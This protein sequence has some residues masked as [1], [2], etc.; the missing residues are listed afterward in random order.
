MSRLVVFKDDCVLKNIELGLHDIVIGRGRESDV[1][2]DDL[3]R[4]VSRAH[5]EVR[6][7]DGG[8]VIVDVGSQNGVWNGTQ[9]VTHSEM[10]PGVS[11]A[12]GAFVLR[13]EED[14]W[15][16]R[17]DDRPESH[18]GLPEAAAFLPSPADARAPGDRRSVSGTVGIA[19]SGPAETIRLT[20]QPDYRLP[21]AHSPQPP[22]LGLGARVLG[23]IATRPQAAT[24][25]AGAALVV[26]ALALAW[27]VWP[28]STA[29]A[30]TGAHESPPPTVREA[31]LLDEARVLFERGS[32]DQARSA[33]R[34]ALDAKPGNAE[35]VALGARIDTAIRNAAAAS[36][37]P[38]PAAPAALPRKATSPG[39]AAPVE[40]S[41]W[42]LLAALPNET[43]A[44]LRERSRLMFDRVTAAGGLVS[45]GRV[46]EALTA[47][48][49]ITAEAPDYPGLS[50]LAAEARKGLAAQAVQAV[51]AGV[52]LEDRGALRDALAQFEHAKQLDPSLPSV[53][54]RI[55]GL[56]D[57]MLAEGRQAYL[58]AKQYDFT[59]DKAKATA[60]Y[61]RVV[62]LLPPDDPKCVLARDR[63]KALAGGRL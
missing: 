12:V 26:L 41:P 28:R 42:P 48:S 36:S 22:A 57:R 30:P 15:D 6:P 61:E 50:D 5:C 27:A 37:I 21:P 58:D 52:A 35:A 60:L 14:E 29:P 24:A 43:P 59:G 46:A 25:A 54:A 55:R 16:R 51:D 38:P 13:H 19:A 45:S 2:L 11:F 8:Y 34:K 32:L 56:Q 63:L 17:A 20:G 53:D 40:P 9:R 10:V 62:A 7:E 1:V 31:N 18:R 33:V 4:T 39:S 44:A 49:G 23:T 3:D 47:I